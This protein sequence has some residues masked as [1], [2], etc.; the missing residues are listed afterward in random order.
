MKDRL[1]SIAFWFLAFIVTLL[2]KVPGFLVIP[3]KTAV[4]NFI[5]ATIW[6]L[7]LGYCLQWFDRRLMNKA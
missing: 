6:G 5:E 7:A 1:L 2:F 4:V 3:G